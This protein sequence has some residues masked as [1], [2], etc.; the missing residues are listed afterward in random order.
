MDVVEVVSELFDV[1]FLVIHIRVDTELTGRVDQLFH[2]MSV[3]AER[4]IEET[5]P[6]QPGRANELLSEGIR[7]TSLNS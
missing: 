1:N 3:L 2:A 5:E 6:S 4:A 7:L